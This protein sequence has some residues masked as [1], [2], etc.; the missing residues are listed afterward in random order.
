MYQ[1]RFTHW[2]A[3]VD[4]ASC[5][6]RCKRSIVRLYNG[7]WKCDTYVS[8]YNSAQPSIQETCSNLLAISGFFCAFARKIMQNR[9]FCLNA[10]CILC[11]MR[12]LLYRI[13]RMVHA[14]RIGAR[15]SICRK[16]PL[17]VAGAAALSGSEEEE[18][19]L[20]FSGRGLLA[21]ACRAAMYCEK[22]NQ[23]RAKKLPAL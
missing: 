7:A 3:G 10:N 1:N 19:L 9:S 22:S 23:T 15:G 12:C 18:G 4:R 11:C 5:F 20:N 17:C 8:D 21:A 14:N 2:L 13:W 6:L 16:H